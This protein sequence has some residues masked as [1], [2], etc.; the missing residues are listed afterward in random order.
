MKL[1][2]FET[3]NGRKACAV[4]KHLN[5]PVEWVRIN[6]ANAEQ[7]ADSFLAVNPN[8]RIPALVDGDVK[9]WESQAIM[10][11]LARKAG[12]DIW[13]SDERQVGVITWFNWDTAH[14]SRY[15][16]SLVWENVIKGFFGLG[17]PDAAAVAQA[18]KSFNQ[19]ARVLDAHLATNKFA[20]GD[21]LTV[22]DFSLGAFLPN[23]EAAKIPVDDYP[24]IKRWHEDLM[25]IPAWKDPFPA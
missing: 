12:S 16:G 17:D 24:N 23:Y 6:L 7:K 11:Y 25:E 3:P 9:L 10:C 20:A 2:Y 19:F 14:F 5:S 15:A 18:T 13:P 1:Y 8:G 4:A 22:A 21:K